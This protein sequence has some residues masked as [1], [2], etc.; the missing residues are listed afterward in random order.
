MFLLLQVYY[1]EKG[2]PVKNQLLKIGFFLRTQRILMQNSC[3]IS[4]STFIEPPVNFFQA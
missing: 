4:P 3:E 2:A 1:K